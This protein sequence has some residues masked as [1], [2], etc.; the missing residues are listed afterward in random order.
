MFHEEIDGERIPQFGWP[1]IS[2]LENWKTGRP[3]WYFSAA[4]ISTCSPLFDDLDDNHEVE[5][6]L[7]RQKVVR[8]NNRTDSE[9]C[10]FVINFST[11]KAA[12]AFIERLNDY[13]KLRAVNLRLA[14]Q[15]YRRKLRSI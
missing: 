15:E 9:S 12:V 4:M 2:S 3:Y 8:K 13:L 11:E 14:K 1:D 10:E 7:R 6:V 5:A